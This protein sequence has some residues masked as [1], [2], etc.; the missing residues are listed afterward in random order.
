MSY[1]K[2]KDGRWYVK[3]KLDGKIKWEYFG[4]GLSAEK[5]AVDRNEELK[6]KGTIQNYTRRAPVMEAP[7]FFELA[8]EYAQIKALTD[9]TPS[10]I[11]AL[12]YKLQAVILPELGDIE[13]TRLT[14][15]RLDQYVNKR[16]LTPV[17]KR[18]GLKI[19][20]VW[21]TTKNPDGTIKLIARST[22]HREL[23]DIQAILNWAVKQKYILS[24]PVMGH[25]KPKRDDAIIKPPTVTETKQIIKHAPPPFNQGSV[26]VLF[27]R[28]TTRGYGTF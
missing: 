10:S 3:Y 7:T 8:T 16:L 18:I 27:H 11:S 5:M 2:K 28:I 20:P 21:K 23:T 6:E 4:R 12:S 15:A 9:M 24:N 13:V 25:Q 22:V 14:H 19:N 26:F 17:K 1:G